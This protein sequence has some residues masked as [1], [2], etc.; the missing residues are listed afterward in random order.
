MRAVTDPVAIA[1]VRWLDLDRHPGPGST[2][3]AL[4]GKQ[5]SEALCLTRSRAG[6]DPIGRPALAG[7]FVRWG[8]LMCTQRIVLQGRSAIYL[9]ASETIHEETMGD[10][11]GFDFLEDQ[12]LQEHPRLRRI[13]TTLVRPSRSSMASFTGEDNRLEPAGLTWE[14]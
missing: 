3:G 5:A 1:R 10:I 4:H 14:I 11:V 7:C 8:T 13:L 9:I 6:H 2:L 12:E